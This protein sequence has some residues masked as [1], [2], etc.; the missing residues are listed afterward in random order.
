MTCSIS[1]SDRCPLYAFAWVSIFI[2]FD[3]SFLRSLD[4]WLWRIHMCIWA[5]ISLSLAYRSICINT[6][7][8][9]NPFYLC[10][11]IL[12]RCVWQ[13]LIAYMDTTVF[14]TRLG[15]WLIMTHTHP[16][17]HDECVP[18]KYTSVSYTT[19]NTLFS[20]VSLQFKILPS[21]VRIFSFGCIVIS[22]MTFIIEF[23]FH[24]N[25]WY[26][27]YEC[28]VPFS[29]YHAIIVYIITFWFYWSSWH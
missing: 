25:A 19:D 29:N 17:T 1:G 2:I 12:I 9:L 5:H 13:V 22:P 4:S 7:T 11:F 20:T 15:V 16:F 6:S 26:H 23:L 18:I 27:S 3:W 21:W 28:H 14:G 10:V 8:V 24:L